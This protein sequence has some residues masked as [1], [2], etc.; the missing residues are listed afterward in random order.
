MSFV[1]SRNRASSAAGNPQLSFTMLTNRLVCLLVLIVCGFFSAYSQNKYDKLPV[2]KI[3]VVFT[4]SGTN[5]QLAEEYRLMVRL[6]IGGNYSAPR[7]REAVAALYDTKK[8]D[9]VVVTAA[10]NAGGDV[11]LRFD[12]KRKTQAERVSVV[13]GTGVGDKVSEQD[14]LFKLNLLTP[15]TAITEQTLQNNANEILDYLRE[16]GFYRS[17]AV[18]E[19]RPLQNENEV[20]VTFKVTPNEQARVED[21]QIKIDGYQKVIPPRSLRLK[22]GGLFSRER[23]LADVAKVRE[24]LRR[25]NFLAPELDEPRFTFDGDT[26]TIA[27]G[28]MGRVGPKVEVT[29]E[30][31]KGKLGKSVQTRLL[32]IKREGT[33]DYSAIVE[34]ERRLANYY[35]EQGYF[36]AKATAYCSVTPPIT[37]A[38]NNLLPN[39]TIFLCG[40]LGS[41][42]LM[43]REVLVKYRVDLDR[44]LRLTRIRVKGT[45][46]LT[47]EDI[48]TVLSSQEANILGII[49]VLGYG[50]GYTSEA[51]LDDDRATIESLMRES[52]TTTSMYG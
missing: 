43:G 7:I 51:I 44:R 22:K 10:T 19:R 8:V 3:D 12:V 23:L 2:S 32:P 33:L 40:S 42:E 52:A 29:V 15:G 5:P 25:D 34:G 46:K 27:I 49:P 14:L 47:V 21:F 26:N 36:F 31:G 35:Q 39:D 6:A 20:G 45:D 41:Q 13:V 38:E 9:T 4:G 28:L 30:T 1:I 18:Y 17:E 48:R 37:D 16:R 24:T 11:E 50:R